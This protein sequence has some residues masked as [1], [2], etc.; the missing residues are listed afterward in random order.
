M[1]RWAVFSLVNKIL[2]NLLIQ[3]HLDSISRLAWQL[4]YPGWNLRKKSYGGQPTGR[5]IE[6]IQVRPCGNDGRPVRKTK[7]GAR[8]FSML[9]L[10]MVLLFSI[11]VTAMAIPQVQSG[12]YRYRTNAAVAMAKWSIQSTRFQALM[13]GAIYRVAFDS[14]TN[15]YQITGWDSNTASYQ[16]VGGPVPVSTW[17][18]AIN[19]NTTLQFSP[20]GSVAALVGS[21]VFTITYQGTTRTITVSNYGN[22][23]VQ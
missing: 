23:T 18:I 16:N 1:P 8:G 19:Q 2:H 13:K 21:N 4:L 22:V 10:V 6:M 7:C 5:T 12:L 14:T 15:N 11:I 20:N 9:E 3:R 17:P